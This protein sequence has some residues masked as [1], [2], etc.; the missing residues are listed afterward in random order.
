MVNEIGFGM[1]FSQTA[2]DPRIAHTPL[3]KLGDLASGDCRILFHLARSN[4][5]CRQLEGSHALCVVNGPDAYISARW[6]EDSDQVPTWN[7][8]SIELEGPVR[9]LERQELLGL[10]TRLTE[11][12]EADISEGTP[13]TMD[14]L[15]PKKREGLLNAIIGFEMRVESHRETFKLSQNKPAGELERLITGLEAQGEIPMAEL[16]RRQSL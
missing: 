12:H 8:T 2:E 4:A 10:L 5:L 6:Y 1:I 3:L 15:T 11:R 16:M 7:Y 14:K 9:K 13:W